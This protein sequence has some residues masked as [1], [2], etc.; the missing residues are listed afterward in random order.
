MWLL[1]VTEAS[2]TN[3]WVFAQESVFKQVPEWREMIEDWDGWTETYL[4]E[5]DIKRLFCQSDSAEMQQTKVFKELYEKLAPQTAMDGLGVEM[6]GDTLKWHIATPRGMVIA[7]QLT[8]TTMASAIKYWEDQQIL[9][10]THKKIELTCRFAENKEDVFFREETW[11]G[12]GE[13][14]F[15]LGDWIVADIA[16]LAV[17]PQS[18]NA[19]FPNDQVGV[20]LKKDKEEV[21][22]TRTLSHDQFKTTYRSFLKSAVPQKGVVVSHDNNM[23]E[24]PHKKNKIQLYNIALRGKSPMEGAHQEIHARH[25]LEAIT[26]HVVTYNIALTQSEKS[27]QEYNPELVDHLKSKPHLQNRKWGQMLEAEL[28]HSLQ[29]VMDKHMTDDWLKIDRWHDDIEAAISGRGSI[30]QKLSQL[31]KVNDAATEFKCQKS[32]DAMA[33][34]YNSLI[35]RLVQAYIGLARPFPEDEV[36]SVCKLRGWET[37]LQAVCQPYKGATEVLARFFAQ[38]LLGE[39][40]VNIKEVDAYQEQQA[41]ITTKMPDFLRRSDVTRELAQQYVKA[42]L[43]A[44]VLDYTFRM[45][46]ATWYK[47]DH[48]YRRTDKDKNLSDYAAQKGLIEIEIRRFIQKYEKENSNSSMLSS[49]LQQLQ[50]QAKKEARKTVLAI[51]TNAIKSLQECSEE[52]VHTINMYKEIRNENAATTSELYLLWGLAHI[53]RLKLCKHWSLFDVNSFNEFVSNENWNERDEFNRAIDTFKHGG[54]ADPTNPVNAVSW[55]WL[56]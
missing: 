6:G 15:H 4:L 51:R 31:N 23:K 29:W 34:M 1:A 37:K 18:S 17:M 14:E 28:K 39:L 54:R 25:K 45:E 36:K 7:Q 26:K 20:E 3:I 24:A 49:E 50:R 27:V 32:D 53:L 56:L 10:K 47:A 13:Q 8:T 16:P 42:R 22:I 30:A 46:A 9:N 33:D 41:R 44:K 2:I 35:L 40:P 48:I 43:K 12:K 52:V 38:E 55:L 5:K 11:G 19:P 21:P